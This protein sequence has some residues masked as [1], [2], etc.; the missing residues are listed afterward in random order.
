MYWHHSNNLRAKFLNRW[1]PYR[2]WRNNSILAIDL[3]DFSTQIEMKHAIDPLLNS[4]VLLHTHHAAS[5]GLQ[6]F[7][8][9]WFMKHPFLP[10]IFSLRIWHLR[11]DDWMI[12]E[13]LYVI[14]AEFDLSGITGFLLV[15]CHGAIH[16]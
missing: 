3:W 14:V 1:H 5:H 10:Q 15:Y 16:L 8:L 7:T 9:A 12:I 13:D 11:Q 6:C 2:V 4:N